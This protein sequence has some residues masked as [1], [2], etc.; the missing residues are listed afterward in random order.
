M[1][2]AGKEQG[3]LRVLI[4]F[5]GSEGARAAVEDLKRAGLP[6]D[7]EALVLACADVA[8]APPC[9]PA[10]V[11]GGLVL[12]R[13][14]I[15]AVREAAERD[16][17]RAGSTAAEGAE[18]VA[19]LLPGWRARGE[20]RAGPAY[21]GIV[22]RA[23]E[24]GAGLIVVGSHGRA[25][26]G[27][28]FFG[29]VTQQVLAHA[30]C[31]VRVG[32]TP[33][34][35]R[36]GPPGG[37]AARLLLAVDGSADSRAAVEALCRREWPPGSEV[38]VVTVSDQRLS[39]DLAFLN[40]PAPRP[41]ISP[42]Q[43]LVDSVGDRL[44]GCRLS[45]TTLLLEGDPKS[46]ILQEAQRWGADCVFLGAQGHSRL[47]RILVGSVSASVAARAPC[48]VEVVRPTP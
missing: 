9:Y 37:G 33:A 11:E 7:A 24:W 23:A 8:V 42:V 41:A 13:A 26:L 43:R 36:A 48:T 1:D 27:R 12:T 2:N 45:V 4:A 38:R 16:L 34:P 40:E 19:G 46:A 20:A 22:E 15:E 5:D 28:F 25:A 32:R 31:S 14:A 6:H 10:T 30:G 47:Q 3:G 44:R 18:L 39:I 29:S 17:A 35:T 21:W